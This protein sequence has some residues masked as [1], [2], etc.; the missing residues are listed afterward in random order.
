[1]TVSLA[2]GSVLPLASYSVRSAAMRKGKKVAQLG[3][4]DD[5]RPPRKSLTKG[6]ALNGE[7]DWKRA[8]LST[9]E[10]AI[11]S[12]TPSP[13]PLFKRQVPLQPKI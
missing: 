2:A 5:N 4:H 8:W 6:H 3:G 1:M 7:K 12:Q 11:F 13:K 9:S 10:G